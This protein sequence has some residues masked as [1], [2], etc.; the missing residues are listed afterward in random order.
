MKEPIFMSKNLWVIIAV[1]PVILIVLPTIVGDGKSMN[2]M[3]GG[4]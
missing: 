3:I 2:L 1:I 4:K